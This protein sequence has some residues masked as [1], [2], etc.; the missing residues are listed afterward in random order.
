MCEELLQTLAIGSETE[1]HV[2]SDGRLESV[3]ATQRTVIEA[4]R[5]PYTGELGAE[6][7]G[8]HYR[9]YF[10]P[11]KGPASGSGFYFDIEIDLSP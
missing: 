1:L 8:A 4:L 3:R 11:L 7:L 6:L 9:R 5:M 10:L 2:Q